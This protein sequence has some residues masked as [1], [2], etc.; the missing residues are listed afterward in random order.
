MRLGRKPRE[1][2]PPVLDLFSFIGWRND[3]TAGKK[4]S[5]LAEAVK[6]ELCSPN[7]YLVEHIQNEVSDPE[8]S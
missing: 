3:V 6:G 1:A 5:I 8:Q 2:L 7:T 4:I